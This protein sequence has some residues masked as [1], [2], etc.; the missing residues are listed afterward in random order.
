MPQ[1]ALSKLIATSAV[2]IALASRLF[3]AEPTAS[4]SATPEIKPPRATS[5]IATVRNL[6]R[7]PVD[8]FNRFEAVE[9]ISAILNGSEMG[10]GDGWFHASQSRYGWD[11]LARRYDADGDKAI[12]E[13][14]FGGPPE[15]FERL[16][17][18]RDGELAP[19]DFDW[20]DKSPFVRQQGQASQWFSRMDKSSNGRISIEEWQQF[21]EKLA[22]EKGYVT[23]SDLRAGVFP[24]APKSSSPLPGQPGPTPEEFIKGVLSGE[25]GSIWEG[26]HIDW[27]AP[28]F[29]LE[30]QDGQRKIRLSSFRNE[31]PVVIVFGSFT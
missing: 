25:L 21:F 11:W 4:P 14:E 9:M 27:N 26:P 31:R 5:P 10:P 24:P 15:L 2:S 8:W 22:G 16:D 23:P 30:T 1:P 17:R 18:N 6:C 28:D 12:S 7:Q 13:K 29:E 20:T 19:D 3:A